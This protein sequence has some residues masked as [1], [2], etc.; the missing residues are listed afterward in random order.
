M[1]RARAAQRAVAQHEQHR[2]RHLAP[3]AP[4]AAAAPAAASAPAAAASV[5]AVAPAVFADA[6]PLDAGARKAEEESLRASQAL[7]DSEIELR[8][9][10]DRV[11]RARADM[12]RAD[13]K[14]AGLAEELTRL[15]EDGELPT[16]K[17]E[18]GG[19]GRA[20]G[21][22][23]PPADAAKALDDFIARGPSK[24][25]PTEPDAMETS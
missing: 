15:E 19:G 10:E 2:R 6:D 7:I 14:L 18:E 16:T 24:F 25:V 17:A 23:A 4:P 1:L 8:A 11:E 12:L 22:A 5:S 13:G 20:A 9:A 3:P 21:G